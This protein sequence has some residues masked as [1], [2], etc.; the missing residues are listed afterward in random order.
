[1]IS[2]IVNK[3]Y[4][5]CRSE[6]D[7]S[8]AQKGRDNVGEVDEVKTLQAFENPAKDSGGESERDGRSDHQKEQPGGG[9]KIRGDTED[10]IHE[11]TATK[12]HHHGHGTDD[13]V[14]CQTGVDQFC[15]AVLIVGR[16]VGGDV[17]DD[18]GPDAKVEQSVV[19]S[20]RKDQNPDAVR[21]VAQAVEDEGRQK[22]PNQDVDAQAEPAGT[23]ILEDLDSAHQE[24]SPCAL[25]VTAVGGPSW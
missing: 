21:R 13:C 22:Y 9:E 25:G 24:A 12:G 11:N 1:M 4:P 8:G 7:E 14:S 10:S 17:T 19:P 6:D 23:Y 16:G 18:R 15:E 5:R 3:P 20:D 2:A